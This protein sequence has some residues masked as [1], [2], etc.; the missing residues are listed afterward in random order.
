MLIIHHLG[1]SQSERIVWLCEELEIPYE[2]RRYERLDTGLAPPEYKR[3]H[4]TGSSPI[5]EDGSL[6][7]SHPTSPKLALVSDRLI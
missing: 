4:P 2:L 5:I 1:L 7:A 3:L 6:A